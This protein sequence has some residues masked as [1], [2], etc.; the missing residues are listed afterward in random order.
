MPL[1]HQ[2]KKELRGERWR[3]GGRVWAGP[4]STG[5]RGRRGK[6][7]S[8]RSAV[9]PQ[10]GLGAS[11]PRAGAAHLQ[12]VSSTRVPARRS[13]PS[14][15]YAAPPPAGQ[16][17]PAARR[18]TPT[19]P[20]PRASP[21]PPPG[22]P[23]HLVHARLRAAPGTRAA[24]RAP[25]RPRSPWARRGPAQPGQG[26][27]ERAGRVAAAA[28]AAAAGSARTGPGARTAGGHARSRRAS[29]PAARRARPVRLR[30]GLGLG[31]RRPAGGPRSRLG[32][33]A[34][35]RVTGPGRRAGPPAGM[36]SCRAKKAPDVTCSQSA[37]TARG[38]VTSAG[39]RASGAD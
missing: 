3:S 28:V 15:P 21:R 22:A 16:G 37:C 13:P 29:H 5:R 6:D 12:A 25:A 30:L 34:Q 36:R 35:M 32:R 4:G 23:A 24:L 33:R 27:G 18:L 17:A 14:A 2:K 31:L 11:A 9:S 7:L 26:P 8:A 38:Q 20:A 10:A 39:A 1:P 19:P